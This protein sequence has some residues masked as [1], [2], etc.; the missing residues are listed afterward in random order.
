MWAR[1]SPALT[2]PH[3]ARLSAPA[4]LKPNLIWFCV[5]SLLRSRQPNSLQ[6]TISEEDPAKWLTQRILSNVRDKHAHHSA[7]TGWR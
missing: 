6:S 3:I 7:I 4:V 1:K 2:R 5:P